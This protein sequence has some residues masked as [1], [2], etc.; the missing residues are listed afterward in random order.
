MRC[1]MTYEQKNNG[2]YCCTSKVCSNH[3]HKKYY[4]PATWAVAI[5]FLKY[6]DILRRP[7][8]STYYKAADWL[9]AIDQ[10]ESPPHG[11]STLSKKKNGVDVVAVLTS[12]F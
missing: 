10:S 11:V 5:V 1:I 2:N 3:S 4:S 9:T 7:E 6:L 12:P 8:R